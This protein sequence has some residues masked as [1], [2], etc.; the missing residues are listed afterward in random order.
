M[1]VQA[2][3]PQESRQSFSFSE[4]SMKHEQNGGSAAKTCGYAVS[5]QANGSQWNTALRGAI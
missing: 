5:Q 3:P 2:Q 4:N 1:L